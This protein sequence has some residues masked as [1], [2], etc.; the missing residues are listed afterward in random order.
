MKL[1]NVDFPKPLLDALRDN[2]LVVFAGAGV[3]IG[4]PARLP[5]FCTLT[6]IIAQNAIETPKFPTVALRD[7]FN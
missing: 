5:D 3:S 2:K 7:P 6:E 1:A 4:E